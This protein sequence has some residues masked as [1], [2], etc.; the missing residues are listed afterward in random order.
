M[1]LPSVQAISTI[2]DTKYFRISSVS[3]VFCLWQEGISGL[4]K[5]KLLGFEEI[6]KY[7]SVGHVH[8]CR[9]PVC[10]SRYSYRRENIPKIHITASTFC[11]KSSLVF[12]SSESV[13]K[14]FI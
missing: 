9:K 4:Q 7:I 13:R 14:V 1:K 8:T 11:I 2:L 10:I 3:E 12:W 5:L 6:K